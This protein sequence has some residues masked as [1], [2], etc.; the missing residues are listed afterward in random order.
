MTVVIFDVVVAILVM[1]YLSKVNKSANGMVKKYLIVPVILIWVHLVGNALQEN[2]IGPEFLQGHL[3]DLGVAAMWCMVVLRYFVHPSTTIPYYQKAV[4]TANSVLKLTVP[5]HGVTTLL[6]I[7]YKVSQVTVFREEHIAKGY[8]GMLD[9]ADI[10]ALC[11]GFLVMVVNHYLL[12]GS[13]RRQ[14]KGAI[15]KNDMFRLSSSDG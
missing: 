2:N 9:V 13:V 3:H 5:L 14:M 4:A 10:A 15:P 1:L 12:R 8:S 7:G 6:C 11:V